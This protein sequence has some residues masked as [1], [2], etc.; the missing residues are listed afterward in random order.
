MG[1]GTSL[2]SIVARKYCNLDQIIITDTFDENDRLRPLIEKSLDLNGL[3]SSE[4]SATN[5]KSS[6]VVTIQSFD[7]CN[8]DSRLVHSLPRI[9][10]LIG[11]DVFFDSKCNNFFNKIFRIFLFFLIPV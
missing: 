5:I 1:A 10:F 4:N 3:A 8:F 7:W 2:P 11:S 9:D 6:G